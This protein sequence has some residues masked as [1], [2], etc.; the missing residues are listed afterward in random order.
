MIQSKSF[1]SLLDLTSSNSFCMYTKSCPSTCSCCSSSLFDMNNNLCDCYYQCP[2][3]CSCKHSFDLTKNYVNCSNR[4]L[5]RIPLNLSP[6]TTHLDLNH[7]QIKSFEKNLTSLTKLQYLSLA[8]NRLESLNPEQFSTLNKIEDL[9][10]SFNQIQT[11]H[12]RTFSNMFNL[13]HL[14]LNHN[15]WIPKFYNG[16][17]EFQS[18]L[19]LNSLTYGNGLVCNRSIIS[20]FSLET[21]L[22]AEDCCK[23][24]INIESCQQ[25]L[26]INEYHH[27]QDFGH[28]PMDG[29][30]SSF[31]PKRIVQ[32]VLNPKYRIYVW[33]GLSLFVLILVCLIIL[34]CL[35]CL[36]RKKKLEK[37][38]SPAERKLLSNG[39]SKKTSNHYHKSFQPQSSTPPQL[40][41]SSSTTALQKLI[42]S[43]RQKGLNSN[44]AYT[45][46]END[47][48]ISYSDDD[49]DDYASI[50]LTVSQTD[51][52]PV[53]RPQPA[54]PPLP[55]PRQTQHQRSITSN[56][57]ASHSSTISTSTTT[58]SFVPGIK[59]TN[60]TASKQ[61]VQTSL[62]PARSCLQ[63]KLDALVLYPINDSEFVHGNIG[64]ILEEMYGKRFSFHFIHR[65]RML[66]E[67]DW[68]IENSC[69]TIIILRK[70]YHIIH[71]YMKTLSSCSSIKIFL[72][73]V[74]DEPKN[75]S[76][77][78][79]MKA[80]EKIAKL[81]RTSN[82]Y[83][84]NSNPLSLIHEQLE[85]FLEQNCGSA[86]YV[87]Y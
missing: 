86:T 19:R 67:L 9:D 56:R 66:G 76:S 83:E 52:T 41:L 43:T 79:S 30:R 17:G 36:C 14:Q 29:D 70:P 35:C 27:Q 65:D 72:I 7:N 69:V 78:S 13:K 68:L 34:C 26:K 10:L 74:N 57:P 16:N 48:S 24:S 55:P 12:P 46:H 1:R 63:I 77:S 28:L 85:L 81:Y 61:A 2:L 20:S 44:T 22:T 60:S 80:R 32:F 33:I 53:I 45:Q 31:D 87:P 37:H 25:S 42:N 6:S 8:N 38:P 40:S 75:Q 15:P 18:N 3:E 59:R 62:Q 4:Y 39:D 64:E 58:R 11:I 84:W 5:N 54:V 50:P 73:L 71:E 47:V 49:E 21:P 82:I 23:H 51:L